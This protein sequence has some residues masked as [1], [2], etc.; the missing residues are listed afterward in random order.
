MKASTRARGWALQALYGWEIRG[1][2][3]GREIRSLHDLVEER[4]V[5]PVHRAY[6]EALVRIVAANRAE[7]DRRIE[8][9]LT[10]WTLER[11]S[12][13]DRTILRIGAAEILY[14]DDVPGPAA[15]REA[16]RL[17]E[18]YGTPQSPAFVNGVLDAV[19]HRAAAASTSP[20]G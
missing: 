10:N 5:S 16:I 20:D 4:N 11:L 9:A 17:A 19:M 1:G 3:R 2:E 15:I 8:E 7:L 14:M 12:A 18:R 13:V 6:A